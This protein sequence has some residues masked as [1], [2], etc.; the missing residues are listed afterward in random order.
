MKKWFFYTLALMLSTC[1]SAQILDDFSDGNFTYSPPWQ[2]DTGHFQVMF[3]RLFLQ[4]PAQTDTSQLSTLIDPPD[5]ASW[6]LDF[7]LD[8]NPSSSN[9]LRWYLLSSEPNF[10]A[11]QEAYFVQVGGT[12]ED[13]I[14][15]QRTIGSTEVMLWES[16]VDVV[17]LDTVQL[18]LRATYHDGIWSLA[19]LQSGSWIPLGSAVDT[20]S[21]P[22]QNT[23]IWC[24]YTSTRSGR[25]SFDDF[26]YAYSPWVD[27]LDP[28]IVHSTILSPSSLQLTFSETVS[29]DNI[30]LRKLPL[31]SWF[32]A[33]PNRETGEIFLLSLDQPIQEGSLY[34][35]EL[36][37]WS[38]LSG[39]TLDSTWT[40]SYFRPKLRDVLITEIMADPTPPVQL[41]QREY[42]E[43]Y[44]RSAHPL[45]LNR[46][47]LSVNGIQTSLSGN[48]ILEPGA[49]HV[50]YDLPSLPNSGAQILLMDSTARLIDAVEYSPSMHESF[51]SDGGWS[52]VLADTSRSCMG[53]RVWVSSANPNGGSP[54]EW[55]VLSELPQPSNRWLSYGYVYNE[56]ELR[57]FHS[58]DSVY[59]AENPPEVIQEGVLLSRTLKAPFRT[60]RI[61][62]SKPMPNEGFH[63]YWPKGLRDCLGRYF[64]PDTLHVLPVS[65][66]DSGDIQISELLFEP[67]DDR[68]EWLEWVNTGKYAVDIGDLRLA[69]YNPRFMSFDQ[70]RTPF[71]QSLVMNPGERWVWT[72][73]PEELWSSFAEL[74][75]FSVH[76][77]TEW[78]S[79]TNDSLS[80]ALLTSGFEVVESFH[81]RRE[82][83]VPFL[84]ETEDVSLE[85]RDFNSSARSSSNWYS[86]PSAREG[87]TP[88]R[89]NSHAE[90]W[91]R[92]KG[93]VNPELF[94]P[95]GDGIADFTVL[96]W[97]FPEPG[98][99]ANVR[100]INLSGQLVF[101]HPDSGMMPK[102]MEWSWSGQGFSSYRCAP[103]IYIWVIEAQDPSGKREFHR[104][105]CV[106]SF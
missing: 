75:S 93:Q 52:L 45:A 71:D 104:I 28:R 20:L 102:N 23:G 86:G 36:A 18:R 38:D 62:F 1:S 16:G 22:F 79:L 50:L 70:V 26:S 11:A 94:T 21:R 48:T 59:W 17:D 65:D 98:W 12:S 47:V 15:L 51:K 2:G 44:N 31:G 41:D 95:N 40:L 77:T 33:H 19:Q 39:R 106:L 78:L 8:F 66:P 101:E 67:S 85:R 103:G 55:E 64:M 90:T 24:R 10:N 27:T 54:G 35:I 53:S 32:D 5:S 80:V 88:T 4:A 49:F 81:Y 89:P 61:Q 13:R 100:L 37:E 58:L 73:D 57:W 76:G 14:S 83:H 69:E 105:P 7:R 63:L 42:I 29:A 30:R 84:L 43:L 6:S 46:L 91:P 25:F 87:A 72:T 92:S 60:E 56:L 68:V 34:Q 97:S 74:D 96:T 3:Q 82:W 99:S 9:Y